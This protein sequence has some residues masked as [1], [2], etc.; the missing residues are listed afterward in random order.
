MEHSS[1]SLIL[2]SKVFTSISTVLVG[3]G[4]LVL[5]V[6]VDTGELVL[7]TYCMIFL[8]M[9]SGFCISYR[10][11]T[12]WNE[13][14]WFKTAMKF[15]WFPAVIV[16]N[17]LVANKFEIPVPLPAIVAAYLV[18]HD[19]RGLITNVGKLTGSDLWQV[20]S[21]FYGNKKKR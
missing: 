1:A 5:A 7:L 3:A 10:D 11:K 9:F 6:L 18:I 8:H 21:D 13:L 12:G 4:T 17:G 15:L 14:K 19:M 2:L 20:L 16:A